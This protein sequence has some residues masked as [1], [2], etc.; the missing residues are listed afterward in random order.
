MEETLKT[1]KMVVDLY[2]NL[3]SE[4]EEI[5]R[6]CK[7]LYF[8]GNKKTI[9]GEFFESWKMNCL[10]L[11]KSTFGSSSPYYDSF[12]NYKFFDYYNSIQ[13]FLGI[14]KG[15]RKD[16]EKGYFFHK[17][18]MLSVNIHASLIKRA[19]E[20]ITGGDYAKA[21][22]ILETTLLEILGKICEN[23]SIGYNE[24]DTLKLF[25]QTL[26]ERRLIP[27]SSKQKL[28]ELEE[29]FGNKTSEPTGKKDLEAVCSWILN[30]LN[31]YL[32][33]QI[34]ILN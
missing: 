34:L 13:I 19:R 7:R 30:F 33:S 24:K 15:A 22:V 25:A 28:E 16:V 5:K 11:L 14:L 3:I 32:G 12:A 2:D 20:H 8:A 27:E 31:D 26:H 10:S 23:K 1:A 6:I 21:R 4:G 17:D 9:D 18:L 29:E